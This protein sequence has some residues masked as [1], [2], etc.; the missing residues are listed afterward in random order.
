LRLNGV[1]LHLV[2]L[3]TGHA[4]FNGRLRNARRRANY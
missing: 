1:L 2:E 4:Y 3:G